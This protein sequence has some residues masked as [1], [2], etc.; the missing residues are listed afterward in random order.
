MPQK[1]AAAAKSKANRIFPDEG[2]GDDA[3]GVT[4]GVLISVLVPFA[5]LFMLKK[6][7]FF[8]DGAVDSFQSIDFLL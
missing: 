4:C 2:A 7:G 1:A 3:I 8:E 6:P 5:V